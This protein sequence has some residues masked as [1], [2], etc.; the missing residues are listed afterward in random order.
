MAEQL[1]TRVQEVDADCMKG[2]CEQIAEIKRVVSATKKKLTKEERAAVRAYR[3]N[4]LE[5]IRAT[6]EMYTAIESGETMTRP[7]FENA[8]ETFV[9]WLEIAKSIPSEH[10]FK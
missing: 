9:K 5:R 8:T 2:I 6:D 10:E 4:M 1:R 3:H 7:K